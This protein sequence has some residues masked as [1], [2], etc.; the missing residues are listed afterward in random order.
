MLVCLS[1]NVFVVSIFYYERSKSI[2]LVVPFNSERRTIFFLCFCLLV[3]VCCSLIINYYSFGLS[4]LH[5]DVFAASQQ[6]DC[7]G[8][9]GMLHLRFPFRSG[10]FL[11]YKT[12]SYPHNNLPGKLTSLFSQ[13]IFSYLVILNERRWKWSVWTQDGVITKWAA[14]FGYWCRNM[15]SQLLQKNAAPHVLYDFCIDTSVAPTKWKQDNEISSFI[16]QTKLKY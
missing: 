3:F 5:Q 10:S 6:H 13:I 15:T 12:K 8:L 2:S 14:Y 11:R 16:Y 7:I 9:P 4:Q 1:C